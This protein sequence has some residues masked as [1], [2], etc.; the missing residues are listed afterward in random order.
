M[1]LNHK[2]F[3]IFRFPTWKAKKELIC[4]SDEGFGKRILGKLLGT[5]SEKLPYVSA[6]C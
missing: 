1:A 6:D 4:Q 5:P 2:R 3:P